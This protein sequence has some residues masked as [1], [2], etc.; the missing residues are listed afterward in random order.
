MEEGEDHLYLIHYY[1]VENLEN[2]Q[3]MVNSSLGLD[4]SK[5]DFM[6]MSVMVKIKM[7][8]IIKLIMLLL[9]HTIIQLNLIDCHDY[10]HLHHDLHD[11]TV[12][13]TTVIAVVI[14]IVELIIK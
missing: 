7:L 5:H 2:I 6:T 8:I 10:Y 12:V 9:I 11:L 14:M 13:T 1:C 4:D 3:K